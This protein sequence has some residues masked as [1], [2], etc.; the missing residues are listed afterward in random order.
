MS[1]ALLVAVAGTSSQQAAGAFRN[2]DRLMAARFPGL[3]RGWT[4]TSGGV[5]RKLAARGDA[6]AAPAA[7]LAALR[8][9][10]ATRGAVQSL[11]L[12]DGMEY[13]ELRAAVEAFNGGADGFARCVLGPPMLEV[14]GLFTNIVRQLLQAVAPPREEETALVLVAHGSR[15]PAARAAYASAADRCRELDPRVVLG[16]IMAPLDFPAVLAACRAAGVRRAYLVPFVIAAGASA[17]GDIAGP[18][19]GSWQ[20]RL[21]AEGIACVPV[22]RGLGDDD[23]IA[24]LWVEQ[25]AELLKKV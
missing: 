21:E 24:R 22:L 16:T 4:Y 6:V 10:G 5:R 15:A 25:A 19:P 23:G 1:Q 8:Q 3:A 9:A 11:H 7:A 13:G 2:V 12:V 17:T 14:P 18:G 20:A